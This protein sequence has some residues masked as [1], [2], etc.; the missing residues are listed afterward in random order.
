MLLLNIHVHNI[1]VI[2]AGYV[3]GPTAAVIAYKNPDIS[4]AVVDRDAR[5]IRRWNSRHL[6]IYEAELQNIVR[7]ACDG[8]GG[9]KGATRRPNLVFSTDVEGCINKADLVFIAV[10]TPTKSSGIGAGAA[11]DLAAFEAVIHDIAQHARPR[12]IVVE[13]ST[14]PCRTAELVQNILAANRPGVHFD[15]ISNPEFL[16][17]GTAMKDLLRPDRI[18]IGSSLTTSGRRAASALADIYAAWVPRARIMGTNVW[19][20]ELAKLAANAMLAQRISSI[21]SISAIC[22]ATGADIDEVAAAVGSDTRIGTAFLKAGDVLS[23]VYLAESLGLSDVAEYW[24]NV[25]NVNTHQLDRFFRRVVRCLNNSLVNKHITILGFAFKA[26]TTDLRESPTIDMIQKLRAEG[27]RKISIFDPCCDP[28]L[29]QKEVNSIDGCYPDVGVYNY[30]YP[31]YAIL[32]CPPQPYTTGP[33]CAEDCP[34]CEMIQKCGYRLAAYGLRDNIDWDR[35]SSLM[36]KPK[37]L[38]DGKGII[39]PEEMAQLGFQVESIGRSR[40]L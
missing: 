37:W 9:P 28:I 38:F 3:G 8:S 6:P 14:V 39:D 23:L 25:V 33:S 1:C 4:V 30:V 18:L 15:V 17:A 11:T 22:E 36:K 16:A 2:G 34:D 40:R 13:K 19:S 35:V 12:T 27:A 21:N 26:N 10:N 5:R 31:A 24:Q 29:S 32:C 7:I 20:A